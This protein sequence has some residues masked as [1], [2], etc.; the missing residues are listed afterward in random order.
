[1]V[2]LQVYLS[3]KESKQTGLILPTITTI[4]T[5]FLVLYS[6]LHVHM[7]ISEIIVPILI[8]G[9]PTCILLVI[10]IRY[11]SKIKVQN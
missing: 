1:M 3:K 5:I 9:V 10:Y 7:P 11:R 8:G 2:Y 4:F 6:I